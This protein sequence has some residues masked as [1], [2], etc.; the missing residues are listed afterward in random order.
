MLT[1][2]NRRQDPDRVPVPGHS[3]SSEFEVPDDL[4][5]VRILA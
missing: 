4:L 2:Q 1:D 5:V 3:S